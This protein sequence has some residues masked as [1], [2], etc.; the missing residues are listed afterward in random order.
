MRVAYQA[1]VIRALSQAGITFDHADGSSGGIIN[2]AMMLSGRTPEEMCEAWRTLDQ[3]RFVS[4]P[5]ARDLFHLQSFAAPIEKKVRH[6][7]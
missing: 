2:L 1:G 5:P 7:L 3:R 4:L 6:K